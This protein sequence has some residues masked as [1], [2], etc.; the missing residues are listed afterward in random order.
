MDTTLTSIFGKPKTF[1]YSDSDSD[2]GADDIEL[3]SPSDPRAIRA[4]TLKEDLSAIIHGAAPPSPRNRASSADELLATRPHIGPSLPSS[5]D[6]PDQQPHPSPQRK[7]SVLQKLSTVTRTA[8]GVTTTAGT[9]VSFPF[10]YTKGFIVGTLLG[11]TVGLLIAGPSGVIIGGKLG[12]TV[13]TGTV[14]IQSIVTIGGVV[15]GGVVG[16]SET[17]QE[18][19]KQSIMGGVQRARSMEVIILDQFG[20]KKKGGV[21]LVRAK[22]SVA[23]NWEPFVKEVLDSTKPNLKERLSNLLTGSPAANPSREDNRDI[24]EMSPDEAGGMRNKVL[25]FVSRLVN[26]KDSDVGLLYNAM[27]AE[28]NARYVTVN[29]SFEVTPANTPVADAHSIIHHLTKLITTT[30]V[31]GDGEAMTVHVSTTVDGLVLG[32]VYDVV[33]EDVRAT[34]RRKDQEVQC[35]ISEFK[36]KNRGW[37]QTVTVREGGTHAYTMLCG[38]RTC[39]DKLEWG[40]RMMEALS[41]GGNGDSADSLLKSVVEHIVVIQPADLFAQVLFC[42]EFV[43]DSSVAMG[44]MGY[45]LI[46]LQAAAHFI[47]DCAD[48]ESLERHLVEADA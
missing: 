39:I 28:F 1:H 31:V 34:A 32:Q 13:G 24:L 23:D 17:V 42:E 41:E 35:R 7:T 29:S 27:V 26:D 5:A 15:G 8:S 22:E 3:F 12:Q 9:I 16:G 6:P 36:A 25:I 40:V 33:F 19:I 45:A 14:C 48:V 47:A 30:T 43:R 38:V 46:T 21:V 20:S 37:E 2:D 18:G 4:T 10:R 44:R 11:S